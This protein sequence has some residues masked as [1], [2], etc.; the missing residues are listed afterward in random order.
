[1]LRI[2]NWLWFQCS[3]GYLHFDIRLEAM[4]WKSQHIWKWTFFCWSDAVVSIFKSQKSWRLLKCI[5]EDQNFSHPFL[6]SSLLIWRQCFSHKKNPKAW[7][8]FCHSYGL[9]VCVHPKD[10]KYTKI[11]CVYKT[12]KVLRQ[13]HISMSPIILYSSFKEV[14]QAVP[15][16]SSWEWTLLWF[17]QVVISF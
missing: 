7:S 6:T 17:C 5:Q 1:M 16:L 3:E 12:K 10:Y 15:V 4:R 2:W 14:Y 13:N 11:K 8:T 9:M